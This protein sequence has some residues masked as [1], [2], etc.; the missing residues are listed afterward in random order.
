MLTSPEPLF[1]ELLQPDLKLLDRIDF[2]R[3]WRAVNGQ[4]DFG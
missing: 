4:R 1:A 3:G 2:S